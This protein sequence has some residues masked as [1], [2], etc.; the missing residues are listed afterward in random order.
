V[1]LP[2][3]DEIYNVDAVWLGPPRNTLPWRARYVAYGVGLVVFV[4]LQAIERRLGIGLGFFSMAYSTLATVGL[5]RLILG[6]VDHDRPLGSVLAAFAHEV[7]APRESTKGIDHTYRPA[8]V[9]AVPAR[10]N[11]AQRRGMRKEETPI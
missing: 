2:V 11:R 4:L 1:R 8:Q 10:P 7:D 5:T 6:V 3:D 9:S